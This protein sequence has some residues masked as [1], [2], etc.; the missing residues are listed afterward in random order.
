MNGPGRSSFM[1]ARAQI[2]IS[3][4]CSSSSARLQLS[5]KS[6]KKLKKKTQREHGAYVLER[7]NQKTRQK[8]LIKSIKLYLQEIQVIHSVRKKAHSKIMYRKRKA[9]QDLSASAFCTQSMQLYYVI[10]G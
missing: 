9:H 7:G 5:Q 8:K 3:L 10:N 1:T 4:F 6:S 2:S